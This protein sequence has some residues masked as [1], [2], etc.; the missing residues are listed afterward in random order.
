VGFLEPLF[1]NGPYYKSVGEYL[2]ENKWLKTINAQN[3][4]AME[5]ILEVENQDTEKLKIY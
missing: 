1:V 2:M 3:D 5:H 4:E